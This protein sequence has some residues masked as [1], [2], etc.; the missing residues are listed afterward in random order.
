NVLVDLN[1][2]DG[3][4]MTL[5]SLVTRL[6]SIEGIQAEIDID[7]RL[8]LRSISEDI[9]FSFSVDS[10]SD[11]SGLLAALGLNTFFTG[12]DARTLSVNQ[13][14]VGN[15]R[16]GARFAASTSGIGEGIENSL[17]LVALYDKS[18]T[19]LDDGSIRGAYEELINHMTQG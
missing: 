3:D 11:E 1:G 8:V 14:L 19:G 4:D 10:P 5:N 13:E 6:N 7:N 17:R 9:D 18:F 2:L 16:A 12:S 15:A